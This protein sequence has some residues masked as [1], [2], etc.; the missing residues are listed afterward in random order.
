MRFSTATDHGGGRLE[1]ALRPF[2]KPPPL[3][4]TLKIYEPQP[5]F[6]HFIRRLSDQLNGLRFR[7][8]ECMWGTGWYTITPMGACSNALE[9]V[10]VRFWNHGTLHSFRF[11]CDWHR[12]QL[13]LEPG[14]PSSTPSID[15]SEATKLK[16][17]T[18][19]SSESS[20]VWIT[21]T[22]RTITP[23][24]EDFRE[25]SIH[26]HFDWAPPSIHNPANTERTVGGEVYRQWMELDNLLV[27]LGESHGVGVMVRYY[28]RE[29]RKALGFVHRMLPEITKRGSTTLDYGYPGF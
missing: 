22:L 17:V 9:Y 29:E 27:R 14:S 4:G 23:E 21:M 19:R 24:H 8:I 25:V 12:T 20:I 10:D 26:T 2:N 1:T 15:F 16:K 11:C 18:F 7:S 3:T 5:G 6:E 28:S 13:V